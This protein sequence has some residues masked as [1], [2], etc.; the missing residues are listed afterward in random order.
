MQDVQTKKVLITA[1]N[2]TVPIDK[3]RSISNIFRGKTGASIA[4]YFAGVGYEVTL[5]T[6]NITIV[7]PTEGL[8]V[9]QYRTYD[10]LYRLMEEYITTK[11]FDV[12]IHSAA[13]SDYAVEGMYSQVGGMHKLEGRP[14]LELTKLDSSGKVGSDHPELWMKLVPTEK[15]IDKIR[16]P[17]GF[18]GAL[19]K[20]KLQV[21]MSDVELIDVATRSMAHSSANLIVANTLE[22]INTKAF[23]ISANGNLPV[24]TNRR[25]LPAMLSY[26][27]LRVLCE[28]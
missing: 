10:D 15:I 4:E 27:V 3:V 11:Q 23:I 18:R 25:N 20:F 13:V 5:L 16:Q 14:M 28:L 7:K 6:S 22:D 9:M 2:T 26:A 21:G 1:G 17:W 24:T 12:I 19:V 8:T